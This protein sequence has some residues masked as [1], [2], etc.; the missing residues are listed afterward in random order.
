MAD[1][2]AL[3]AAAAPAPDERPSYRE[4]LKDRNIAILATSRAA[5]KLALATVSDGSMV[6]LARQ[7]ASQFAISLVVALFEAT[8]TLLP[9]AAVLVLG[10]ISNFTGPKIVF[11]IAPP[12]V[13][14]FVVWLP[15]YSYRMEK[16]EGPSQRQAIQSLMDDSEDATF[17]DPTMEGKPSFGEA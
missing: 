12:V 13:V 4:V 10:L 11:I 8:N 7:D 16:Q 2:I 3:G 6:Y 9:L 14:G 1:A 15:R 5:G 17:P